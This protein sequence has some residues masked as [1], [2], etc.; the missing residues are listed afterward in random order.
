MKGFITLVLL[1]CSFTALAWDGAV[2]GKVAVI[3]VTGGDNYGFRISLEGNPSLCG[4]GNTWAYINQSD[5]NYQTYAAVLLAAKLAQ[6]DVTVY[7]VQE[8]ISGKGYCKMGYI[9]LR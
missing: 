6:K 3:D 1:F 2:A 9:S 4:N 5:S 7:S 8:S